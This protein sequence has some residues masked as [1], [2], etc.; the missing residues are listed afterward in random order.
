MAQLNGPRHYEEAERRIDASDY[1][2]Q[3]SH[4]L[5]S[6]LGA[7]REALVAQA[8]ATLAL[9]SATLDAAYEKSGRGDWR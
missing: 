7:V 2:W 6:A 8:H 4:D 5:H 9:V 3:D 1:Q